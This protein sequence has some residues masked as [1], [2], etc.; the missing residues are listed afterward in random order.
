MIVLNYQL[1]EA[2]DKLDKMRDNSDPEEYTLIINCL[3]FSL[4]LIV[5]YTRENSIFF[6]PFETIISSFNRF[7]PIFVKFQIF[8]FFS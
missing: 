1:K 8:Y 4:S 6:L 5:P 7:I 2:V 3:C